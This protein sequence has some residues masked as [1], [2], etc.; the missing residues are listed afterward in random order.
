M[1]AAFNWSAETPNLYT[2]VVKLTDADGKI[3]D[4]V[5]THVGFRTVEIKDGV[6]EGED[7][8]LNPRALLS[9]KDRKATKEDEKMSPDRKGGPKGGMPGEKGKRGDVP[10]FNAPAEGGAGRLNKP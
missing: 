8:V 3:R 7:I 4:I 2:L 5:S 9:E 1:S 6:R 10:S